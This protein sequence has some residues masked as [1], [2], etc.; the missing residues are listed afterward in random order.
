MERYRKE[1]TRRATMDKLPSTLGTYTE[2]GV[3]TVP[4][5]PQLTFSVLQ[6]RA[7]QAVSID[8]HIAGHHPPL[9]LK[10]AKKS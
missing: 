3:T 6:G 5:S 7:E 4:T 2:L 9:T 1:G 8:L 10:T